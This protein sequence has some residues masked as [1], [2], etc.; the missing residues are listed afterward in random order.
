MI[1]RTLG[2]AQGE[3]ILTVMVFLLKEVV[4]MLVEQ[5]TNNP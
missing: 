5:S 1:K 2:L 4:P 3:Y